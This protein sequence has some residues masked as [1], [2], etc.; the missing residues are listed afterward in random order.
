M[1]DEESLGNVGL[2]AIT[3]LAEA[4]AIVK[5]TAETTGVPL[6]G[7]GAERVALWALDL[8]NAYRDLA[9]ARHE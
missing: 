6:S 8:T 5:A 3:K 2:P 9:A 1:I 7:R 4:A